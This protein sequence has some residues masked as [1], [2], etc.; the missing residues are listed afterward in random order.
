MSVSLVQKF[1]R[2]SAAATLCVTS[3]CAPQ[4]ENVGARY[5]SPVTYQGYQC[6]QLSEEHIRLSREVHRIS[7]L[8]RENATGDAVMLTFGLL[9][10]WPVLIGMAATK[11]RKDEL[12]KLK[13]EYEAVEAQLKMKQC[14]AAIPGVPAP[15]ASPMVPART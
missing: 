9:I 10:L 5:V 1:C 2:I 15:P 3:A 14:P 6:D 7:D 4:P 13:G 11:D 12:G 8:Q